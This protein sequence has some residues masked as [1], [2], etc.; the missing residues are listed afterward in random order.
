VNQLLG[1]TTIMSMTR[2][3]A[4][5]ALLASSVATGAGAQDQPAAADQAKT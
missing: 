2:V 5:A 1:G 4:I 3:V